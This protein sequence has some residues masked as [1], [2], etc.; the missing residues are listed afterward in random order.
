MS[1]SVDKAVLDVADEAAQCYDDPLR[2]VQVMYPWGEPGP[3]AQ[4]RGPDRWQEA[5]LRRLGAQVQASAR[6]QIFLTNQSFNPG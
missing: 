1:R 4:Y 5:F 3:L 2:F 6:P